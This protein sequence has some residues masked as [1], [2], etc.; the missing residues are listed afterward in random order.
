MQQEKDKTPK[1]AYEKPRLRIIELVADE[2]LAVGCKTAPGPFGKLPA[3]G[4][5]I[6]AC[7]T[8]LGS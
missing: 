1:Q 7:S 4:C 6:S 2:I 8:S 5:T 3:G